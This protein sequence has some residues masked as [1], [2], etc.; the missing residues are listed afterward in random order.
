MKGVPNESLKPGSSSSIKI[1][2]HRLSLKLLPQSHHLAATDRLN[3]IVQQEG[4]ERITLFLSNAFQVSQCDR[5]EGTERSPLSFSIPQGISSGPGLEKASSRTQHIFLS[6]PKGVHSGQLIQIEC[7]YKGV[8]NHPPVRSSHLKF[9]APDQTV[10][11]IGQEGVYL[12]GETQ[13]YLHHPGALPTFQLEVSIPRGWDVVTHG[14]ETSRQL[15]EET[16]H[17]TWDIQAKT[18]ALTL[19]ANHF[20]KHQRQWQGIELSTYLFPE[21]AKLSSVYLDAMEDYLTV[22]SKLIGP[23]PFPKFSVVE[24][25]FPSGLGMPSFTLLGSGVIKRRYVQPYALGHEIVHSWIGNWVYNDVEQGNWVEGLTTYLSNYYY[26][27]LTGTE[28]QA[29]EQRRKMLLGYAVYVS[30]EEDYPLIDFQFKSEQKD[31]AIGYQKAAMVFHMLRR[32]IGNDPFWKGIR[33]LVQQHAQAYATWRDLER[34]FSATSGRN[35]QEFFDQWVN[36]D[37]A[38]SL[39]IQDARVLPVEPTSSDRSEWHLTFQLQQQQEGLPFHMPV[40]LQIQLQD[41]SLME[42]AVRV[43]K[44]K[45]A[46]QLRVDSVPKKIWIDPAFELFQRLSRRSL[47]P[48]LNL[49]VTDHAPTLVVPDR[50]NDAERQPYEQLAQRIVTRQEGKKMTRYSPNDQGVLAGS[51]LVLGGPSINSFTGWVTEACGNQVDLAR[52]SFSIGDQTY[53]APD[54]ALLVSCRSKIDPEKT[55]T[56]FYGLTPI[57]AGKVA[58]LLFFYGWDS[59]VVFQNG[60]VKTRGDF[61]TDLKPSEVSVDAS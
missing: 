13:W 25:F 48:M 35:L 46:Y 12:S 39:S 3:L 50:G 28:T 51:M 42:H 4:L 18:E 11:H 56:L 44:R 2:H 20:I 23:Y 60:R 10:G 33:H 58:R 59:Y 61:E 6:L 47:P 49:F 5:I 17:T 54:M 37:G 45:Q 16:I 53:D 38:P 7:A 32:E 52:E 27:E 14:K 19:V 41:G 1:V 26:E 36:R 55:V 8:V 43:T 57:A 24:N 9:V 15:Q 31:N 21:D 30:P 34:S 22:Y 29:I 40:P